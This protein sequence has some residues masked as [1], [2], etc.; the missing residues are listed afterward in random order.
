MM[1]L[2]RRRVAAVA[3]ATALAACGGGSGGDD[4]NPNGASGS[5]S[6]SADEDERG[7]IGVPPPAYA[8]CTD[9]GYTL[10]LDLCQFPDGSSCE[11]WMFF[12][13]QCGQPFSYCA[14]HGGAVSSKTE[15]IGTST[16]V[17]SVCDLAGQRCRES[18]FMQTGKCVP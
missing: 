8:Y 2:L 15:N 17:Y 16:A 13:G 1:F 10:A 7:T 5:P 14:K 6:A 3:T 18:S 12:R 4:G 11:V 9:L